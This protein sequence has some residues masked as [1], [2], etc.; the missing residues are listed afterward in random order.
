MYISQDGVNIRLS[1]QS[2]SHQSDSSRPCVFSPLNWQESDRPCVPF[3]HVTNSLAVPVQALTD[4][5]R[6]RLPPYSIGTWRLQGRQ[7]YAPAAFTPH[8]RSQL[9]ISVG[10]Q[11]RNTAGRIKPIK[12]SRRPH[13]ESN[14]RP[15]GFCTTAH[16][17][18]LFWKYKFCTKKKLVVTVHE[19]C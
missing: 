8:R 7:P 13:R 10:P 16:F 4:S 1:H 14:P 18:D 2:S 19:N 15:F 9:L 6:F 11:G 5:T 12:K 17:R 3:S